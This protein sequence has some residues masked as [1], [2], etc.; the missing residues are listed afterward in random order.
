MMA[1]SSVDVLLFALIIFAT[2]NIKK[3]SYISSDGISCTLS[4]EE[5]Y[6]DK[7]DTHICSSLWI[8]KK[9]CI[10][11]TKYLSKSLLTILLIIAGDIEIQP[12]PSSKTFLRKKGI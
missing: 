7:F 9:N 8:V 2:F 12:G 11:P 4:T 10:L 1:A 5:V 3:A 6:C